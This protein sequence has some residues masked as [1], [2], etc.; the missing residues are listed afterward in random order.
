M[1]VGLLGCR[2]GPGR[3]LDLLPEQG[4]VLTVVAVRVN[5]HMWDCFMHKA[6]EGNLHEQIL[7]H[8]AYRCDIHYSA[9]IR[10]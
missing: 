1:P 2:T 8:T 3:F 5:L 9:R 10:S 4:R 6:Q 7:H